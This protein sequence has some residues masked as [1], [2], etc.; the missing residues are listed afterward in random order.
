MDDDKQCS[1]IKTRLSN[2]A[3]PALLEK[4]ED[5]VQ[6]TNIIVTLAY[7]FIK[8][9]ILHLANQSK[10]LPRI[11][12]SFINACMQTIATDGNPPQSGRCKESTII[13][14]KQLQAFYES[15]FKSLM[16][17]TGVCLANL[18]QILVYEMKDM[19]QH[20]QVGIQSYSIGLSISCSMS[21]RKSK[22]NKM[23]KQGNA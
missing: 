1:V 19:I 17:K 18:T 6:R 9:Y 12:H 4:I 16:P 3:K 8:L 15:H 7:Q 14:L 11:D 10:P 5:V 22:I 13:L 23:M 21:K 2:I 20:I